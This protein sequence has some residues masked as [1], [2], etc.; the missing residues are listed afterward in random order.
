MLGVVLLF[1]REAV[2]ELMKNFK[3]KDNTAKCLQVNHKM[4]NQSCLKIQCNTVPSI[5]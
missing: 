4:K 3:Y 5:L 2:N 1:E